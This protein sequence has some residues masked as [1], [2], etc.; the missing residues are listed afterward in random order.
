MGQGARGVLGGRVLPCVNHGVVALGGS[1]THCSA[2][3]IERPTH[4]VL[5]LTPSRCPWCMHV[6]ARVEAQHGLAHT[7]VTHRHWLLCAPHDHCGVSGEGAD[8]WGIWTCG[9]RY[10]TDDSTQCSA[11][12]CRPVVLLPVSHNSASSCDL[13]AFG[14]C[15]C[16]LYEL[17]PQ[18]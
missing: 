15:R 11:T 16:C 3:A 1:P 2:I 4:K 10:I 6:W 12:P 8:R 5:D 14:L 9:Q 18:V 7:Q 17:L 13:A